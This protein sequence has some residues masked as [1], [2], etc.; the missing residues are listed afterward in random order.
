MNKLLHHSGLAAS[1]RL[2]QHIYWE[3]FLEMNMTNVL[4]MNN[5][6]CETLTLCVAGF[7]HESR[8]LCQ[9]CVDFSHFSCQ[10]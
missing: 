2:W 4:E 7:I 3:E 6:E 8:I 5:R 1:H 9:L 10:R